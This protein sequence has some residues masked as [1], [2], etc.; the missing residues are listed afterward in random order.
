MKPTTGDDPIPVNTWARV[1]SPEFTL[2]QADRVTALESIE[3]TSNRWLR[4]NTAQGFADVRIAYERLENRVAD[5]EK[6]IAERE[7]DS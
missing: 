6:L 5:L 1:I 3:S 2:A 7:A 4:E